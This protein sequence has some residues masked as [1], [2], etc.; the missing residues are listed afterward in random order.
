MRLKQTV[1]ELHQQKDSLNETIGSL[2]TDLR[3]QQTNYG[4][5]VDIMP[6]IFL[7]SFYPRPSNEKQQILREPSR[8]SVTSLLHSAFK[9]PS[10]NSK[11]MVSSGSTVHTSRSIDANHCM[12]KVA[13]MLL[14]SLFSRLQMT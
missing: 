7:T 10:L 2:C 3:T 12:L 5:F 13:Y 1:Q 8:N 14:Q 11:P 9:L 6:H 4:M